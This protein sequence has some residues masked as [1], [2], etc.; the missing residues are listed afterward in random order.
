MANEK[1]SYLK[2][3]EYLHEYHP[4]LAPEPCLEVGV[5]EVIDFREMVKVAWLV[6]LIEG[7]LNRDTSVQIE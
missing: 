6:A 1:F 3:L 2:M 5:Y 7:P 4:H